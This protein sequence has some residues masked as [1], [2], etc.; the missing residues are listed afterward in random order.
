MLRESSMSNSGP[1]AKDR[2]KGAT[3][4][5]IWSMASQSRKCSDPFWRGWKRIFF[6]KIVAR[7]TY[8]WRTPEVRSRKTKIASY[9]GQIVKFRADEVPAVHPRSRR[10]DRSRV[11]HERFGSHL[12]RFSVSCLP[13]IQPESFFRLTCGAS[14]ERGSRLSKEWPRRYKWRTEGE[15]TGR[16]PHNAPAADGEQIPCRWLR[17]SPSGSAARGFA[18][19]LGADSQQ[20][21]Q[22]A[23]QPVCWNSF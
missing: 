17:R 6:E 18:A 10:P 16:W 13:T 9:V 4:M 22:L 11:D 21:T 7:Y 8:D 20:V 19:E 23:T 5:G 14:F 2:M 3:E 12:R 15:I 1:G